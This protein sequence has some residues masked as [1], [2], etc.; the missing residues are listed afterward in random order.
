M[1]AHSVCVRES[2]LTSDEHYERIP[3]L[4]VIRFDRA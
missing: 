4:S 3:G 2:I 1:G